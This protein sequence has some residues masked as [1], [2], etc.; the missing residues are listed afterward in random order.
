MKRPIKIGLT[1]GIGAGKSLV[2]EF[3]A[4]KGVPIL[5]TDVLGHQLL[6][7]KNFSKKIVRQFGEDVTGKKGEIDR[8][9]LGRVIF[10]DPAKRQ[11]LNRLMHPE[12]RKRVRKW[13]QD[14]RGKKQPY[15]LVVVEVP[16]LFERGFNHF[17][18]GVLCVSAPL[19]LRRKRLL[20]RGLRLAEIK[21]REIAQWT[22]SQKDKKADW[23]IFNQARIID[24]KYA[25]KEWLEKILE[26][27]NFPLKAG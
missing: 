1:G 26:T 27:K 25:V 9:K 3:L 24:L 16:L 23:V 14:Q 7:E 19:S 20:K 8:K 2:L 4:E 11:Q 6:R 17:F 10:Q 22:Q 13:V 15:P 21:K 18:D 5:Q 12:I